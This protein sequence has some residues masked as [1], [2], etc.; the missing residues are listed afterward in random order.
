MPSKGSDR[1]LLPEWS[2]GTTLR[3]EVMMMSRL[4]I[5]PVT[6]QVLNMLVTLG[7]SDTYRLYVLFL[8]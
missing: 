5:V 1:L 4:L 7:Y 6:D 2:T 3:H 8:D